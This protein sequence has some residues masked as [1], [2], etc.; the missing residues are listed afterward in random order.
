MN[1][2]VSKIESYFESEIVRGTVEKWKV[3]SRIKDQ[4]RK[5]VIP[6]DDV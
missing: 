5:L 2:D 1:Q 3:F 6:E 4:S